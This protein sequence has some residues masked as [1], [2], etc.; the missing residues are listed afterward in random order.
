MSCIQIWHCSRSKLPEGKNKTLA[1]DHA[2]YFQTTGGMTEDEQRKLNEQ[3]E[4]YQ[5][6]LE[7]QKEE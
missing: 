6:K 2:T 4:E 3:Y 1:N 5:K 7:Q